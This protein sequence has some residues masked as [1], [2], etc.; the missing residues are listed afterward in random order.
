MVEQSTGSVQV[1]AGLSSYEGVVLGF[2]VNQNNFLG[3]GNR[4]SVQ[5]NTGKVN[6]TYS[7]SY[8]DPYFT[9]DGVSRGFDVYRR[10]VNTNSLVAVSPYS[11]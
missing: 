1:G 3:T 5:V 11:S 6:T 2:T 4:V 9:P 8:T 7:L 10:D